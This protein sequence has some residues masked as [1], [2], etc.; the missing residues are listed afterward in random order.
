M[1]LI[2]MQLKFDNGVPFSTVQMCILKHGYRKKSYP[3]VEIFN[4]MSWLLKQIA[5][6]NL[7]LEQLLQFQF[8]YGHIYGEIK[9]MWCNLDGLSSV[10]LHSVQGSH[11]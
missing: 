4:S 7:P 8:N 5:K 10:P 1:Q 3:F 9:F 2:E 11:Q 6:K